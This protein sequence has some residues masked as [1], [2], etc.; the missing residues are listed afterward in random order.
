MKSKNHGNVYLADEY[1]EQAK[2]DFLYACDCTAEMLEEFAAEG[3][4]T[5]PA[6][7]GALTQLIANLLEIS[8]NQD[9][10]M[11]MISSCIANA[12]IKLTTKQ[13]THC[14]TDQVH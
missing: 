10:A 6:L 13:Q 5:G 7:G 14:S 9:A 11:Q 3:L 8:P 2:E 12:S 1:A 4:H